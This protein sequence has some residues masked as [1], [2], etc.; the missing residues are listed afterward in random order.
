VLGV[1]HHNALGDLYLRLLARGHDVRVYIEDRDG[2]DI[3]EGMVPRSSAWRADLPWLRGSVEASS[4]AQ[5][6]D[7]GL[8]LFESTGWG[9]QQDQ[10]R[11]EGYRVVGSSALGDRLELDRTFGQSVARDL[12]MCTAASVPFGSFDEALA[13][14][15]AH[16]ARYV[17]KFDGD[18]F[19]KTRNYVGELD[20]GDDML[21]MLRLQRAKWQH[22]EAPRFVL[23]RHVRGVEVGVGGFFDGQRFLEPCNLDW[24]HKRFFPGNLGELTGEMGTVVSYRRAARLFGATLGRLAPLLREARHVGYVNLNMIVNDDGAFPLEFTCRFGVPGFAVLSALHRDPWDVLLARMVAGDSPTF[25]TH[26]GFAV[27]VVL[28]VPPFPYPDGYERLSK[29]AP[30]CLHRMSAEELEQLHYGEMRLDGEQ[31][32]TAG[33][34][35]YVMVVTGRGASV[36]DARTKAYELARKVVVPNMRYRNDIGEAFERTDERELIRLG[37][38]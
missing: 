16:P 18:S 10:L 29:G 24:E 30:I 19:A 23:M 4:R 5:P 28:T 22:E 37:W 21:A 3:L 17:L 20:E 35:G 27:G 11:R 33:Q 38:L 12:G 36:R 14:V 8:L 13:F 31:L 2:D 32:V 26:D 1:G 6:H 25:Q 7:P 34:I 9:E 15:R